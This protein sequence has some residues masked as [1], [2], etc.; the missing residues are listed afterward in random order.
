MAAGA[1]R[2]GAGP[3]PIKRQPHVPAWVV[4]ELLSRQVLPSMQ[5][6][7]PKGDSREFDV[8]GS[9][10]AGLGQGFAHQ[11]LRACQSPLVTASLILTIVVA[12]QQ[13]GRHRSPCL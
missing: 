1:D 9:V 13:H 12:W 7:R 8:S 2:Q 11:L 10:N 4:S 6:A 3:R 5:R